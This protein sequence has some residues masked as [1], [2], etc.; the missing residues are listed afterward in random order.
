[1]CNRYQW[2]IPRKALKTIKVDGHYANMNAGFTFS[3]LNQNHHDTFYKY[4]VAS[5]NPNKFQ[6]SEH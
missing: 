3:I 5:I 2:N 6:Q 1:M 4:F